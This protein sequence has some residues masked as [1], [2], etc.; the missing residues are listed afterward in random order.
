MGRQ[1]FS[2]MGSAGRL[3]GGAK[4]PA[5]FCRNRPYIYIGCGFFDERRA[6]VV[7]RDN[8]LEEAAQIW[9]R[10]AN[11]YP[12]SDQVPMALFL[13]GI[14]RYRLNDFSGALTT[15]QR[16][17]LFAT[18]TGRP[19]PCII[20]GSAS[21]NKNWVKTHRL[22]NPGNRGRLLIQQ[23]ITACAPVT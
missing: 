6:R 3:R 14:A 23:V 7:E 15:F 5:R 17:L 2:R 21:H 12:A 9:E 22:K 4:D 18:A 10:V 11:E 19:G 20:F 13:A 16:D 8:R 1:G